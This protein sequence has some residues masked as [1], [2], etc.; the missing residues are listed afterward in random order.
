VAGGD[1]GYARR[2]VAHAL[3]EGSRIDT[4]GT[5]LATNLSAV[6]EIGP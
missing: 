2:Q 3:F 4:H 1:Q 5:I 6:S